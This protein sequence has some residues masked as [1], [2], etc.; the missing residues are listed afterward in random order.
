M[1]DPLSQMKQEYNKILD[2]AHSAP[3][4]CH[5]LSSR[6][7]RNLIIF[8]NLCVVPFLAR[9]PELGPHALL[10][11]VI[12]KWWEQMTNVFAELHAL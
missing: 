6:R 9:P 7:L 10:V 2:D 5:E 11:P 8:H 3:P 1:I 12:G 4:S